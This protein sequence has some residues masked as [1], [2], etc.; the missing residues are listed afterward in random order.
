MSLDPTVELN[1]ISAALGVVGTLGTTGL[2]LYI[3]SIK[4]DQKTIRDDM[5]GIRGAIDDLR[6]ES[7]AFREACHERHQDIGRELAVA[8]RSIE[9]MDARLDRIQAHLPLMSIS[10]VR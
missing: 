6:S 3:R 4:E 8:T 9:D 7:S 5:A 1:M 2:V 10:Q